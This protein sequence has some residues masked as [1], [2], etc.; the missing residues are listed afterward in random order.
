MPYEIAIGGVYFPALLFIFLLSV[1]IHWVLS[2]FLEKLGIFTYVWHPPLF[3]LALFIC[4]FAGTALAYY[5]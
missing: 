2:Y 1:A 4:L 3:Q 5:H